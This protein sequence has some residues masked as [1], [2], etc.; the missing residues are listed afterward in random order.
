MRQLGLRIDVSQTDEINMMR[1][2]LQARGQPIP[3]PHAHHMTA[4]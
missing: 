2:W 4:G 3:G 1:E